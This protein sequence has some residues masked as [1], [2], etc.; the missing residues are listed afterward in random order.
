MNKSKKKYK[1]DIFNIRK[2]LSRS[3]INSHDF[4]PKKVALRISVLYLI[5]GTLWILISDRFLLLFSFNYNL[6]HVISVS[7]GFFYVMLTSLML[8]V[9]IKLSF[10]KIQNTNKMLTR[11]TEQL[12]QIAYKDSLTNLPNRVAFYDTAKAYIDNCNGEKYAL[13][14]LDIDNL[15]YINDTLGHD[16]GD[17]IIIKAG[18]IL[19]DSLDNNKLLYRV[20]GDEFII[21]IT[22]Y[23]AVDEIESYVNKM[24]KSLSI[25]FDISDNITNITASF[26]ISLYPCHAQDVD[27]LLKY[28]DLALYKAKSIARGGYIIYSHD[29]SEN[30][31]ERVTLINEL[32]GALDNREFSLFYQP[33]INL[34]TGDIDT[35]EALIR[36]NNKK[37]GYVSPLKFINVA[38]ETNLINKIGDWV[39]LNACCFLKSLHEQGYSKISMAVN[40]SI[41]Q[42]LQNDFIE[43]IKRVV[44]KVGIDPK[45]IELEITE[46]VLIESYEEIKDKLIQLKSMGIKIALDDFGNGYSSL[47]YLTHIPIN[48]LKIDKSFIDT[49]T[50]ENDQQSLTGMIIMI[51]RKLGLS[52]VAEGVETDTQ[53]L[54]LKNHACHKIQGYY[55]YKPL[56]KDDIITLLNNRN[57]IN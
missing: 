33:Q 56:P 4:N 35:L 29:I 34:E 50:S 43:K 8:Y 17:E 27:T 57:K 54:Y 39:L 41:I 20:G 9:L 52:I 6:M 5:V 14:I 24:L 12:K 3:T 42:L 13:I 48:T 51:G 2:L 37:M 31:Q 49:I 10:Q 22:H 45:F 44:S 47:S 32:R 55:F 19:S 18:K 26:G 53:L 36:W 11:Q 38:E 1:L 28:A 46:S 16:F 30:V 25:P 40:I 7:K 21:F 23:E 15:K